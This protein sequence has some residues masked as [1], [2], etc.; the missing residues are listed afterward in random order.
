MSLIDFILNHYFNSFFKEYI[1]IKDIYYLSLIS[2]NINNKC[3][4]IIQDH[5]S[6]H[7]LKIEKHNK[8]IFDKFIFKKIGKPGPN[9]IYHYIFDNLRFE[10][11]IEKKNQPQSTSVSN[12]NKYIVDYY[13]NEHY[14]KKYY[15]IYIYQIN[16]YGLIYDHSIEDVL[17]V[18]THDNFI[19]FI[20][21]EHLNEYSIKNKQTKFI[22]NISGYSNI[23]F[24]RNKHI[25]FHGN[26]YMLI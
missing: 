15:T 19:Y 22:H 26:K 9:L 14:G 12:D 6:K 23:K 4:K 10:R 20:S 18:N 3:S 17:Y 7:K 24:Y 5:Y 16:E 21:G 13:C 1:D 11:I 8:K 25:Y 2:K